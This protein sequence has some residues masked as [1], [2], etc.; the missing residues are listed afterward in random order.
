MKTKPTDAEYDRY[1]ELSER[2]DN[3]TDIENKEL[4]R[5]GSLVSPWMYSIVGHELAIEN[6]G[7]TLVKQI[8]GHAK[9]RWISD[10]FTVRPQH[11]WRAIDGDTRLLWAILP[12]NE[13]PVYACSMVF[14]DGKFRRKEASL[15]DWP[16]HVWIYESIQ[17]RRAYKQHFGSE[18][19]DHVHLHEDEIGKWIRKLNIDGGLG[20]LHRE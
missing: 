10:H 5:L 6:H 3:M 13:Q 11:W 12:F 20:K 18:F 15:M 1:F 19:P 8:G 4:R 9:S 14:E 7:L 16:F 2:E 17:A